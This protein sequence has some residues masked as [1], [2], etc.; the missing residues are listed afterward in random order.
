MKV[1]SISELKKELQL[2]SAKELSELCVY[3]AK[4]KKDNKE[5]LDYLLFSAHDKEAFIKEV[6]EEIDLY[7]SSI[8]DRA[9]LYYI[10]KSLRKILRLVNKYCKYVGDKAL[11]A[12]LHI[13]FCKKLKNS[14]I[15]FSKSQ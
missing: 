14:S 3:I 12:E 7:F 6:K 2:L 10:K 4:Y 9:N 13:Y 8:D 5:Y 15:P 11:N 1:S